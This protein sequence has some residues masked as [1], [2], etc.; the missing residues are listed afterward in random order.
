MKEEVSFNWEL[1]GTLGKDH[2]FND[3]RNNVNAPYH[4]DFITHCKWMILREPNIPE[5]CFEESHDIDYAPT[6]GKRLIDR[7]GEYG[8]Q[9]IVQMTSIEL[10]PESP[11]FRTKEWQIAGQANEHICAVAMYCLES[12]NISNPVVQFRAQT[13]DEFDNEDFFIGEDEGHA[14][15][16]QVYGTPVNLGFCIQSYGNVEMRTGR[17]LAFP[18]TL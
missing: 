6:I 1:L 10:T 11:E 3:G 4:P 18:N 15:L 2:G 5:P 13:E 12:H 8:L 7:Y 14:F 17:L 16:G 9:V